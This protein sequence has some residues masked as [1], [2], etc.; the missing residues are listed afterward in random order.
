[1]KPSKIE[2]TGLNIKRIMK[3]DEVAISTCGSPLYVAS[4]SLGAPHVNIP[5]PGGVVR[6]ISKLIHTY[7]IFLFKLP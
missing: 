6:A 5:L 7:C 2:N 3:P 1:M 4:C